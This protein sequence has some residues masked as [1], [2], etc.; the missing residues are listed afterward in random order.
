MRSFCLLTSMELILSPN[1]S[2]MYL[3]SNDMN[4][5]YNKDPQIYRSSN[6]NG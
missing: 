3:H 1:C 2:L 6:V 5:Y 4:N